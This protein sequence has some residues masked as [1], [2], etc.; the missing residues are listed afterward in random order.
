[1]APPAAAK[2]T[3]AQA[4]PP[5]AAPG[6][7]KPPPP[8]DTHKTTNYDIDKTVQVLEHPSWTLRGINIAVL[9]NNPADSPIPAERLQAINKLVTSAVGV[10]QNPRV[11]VVD[12][13]FD[14][15]GSAVPEISPVWWKQPWMAAV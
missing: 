10:A 5:A 6:E 15:S 7:A 8:T 12:L 14:T 13:P 2:G 4:T 3:A 1:P 9:V 11:T